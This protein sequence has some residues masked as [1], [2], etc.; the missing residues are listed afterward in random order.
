MSQPLAEMR[1]VERGFRVGGGLFGSPRDLRAVNGVSLSI[2]SGEALGIVGES[3][4]GKSTLARM[5]LGL[6]APS[7]GEVFLDGRPIASLGARALARCVQ[8]VFQDPYSSLN[9]RRSVGAI[10]AAPLVVH[11]IGNAAERRAEVERLIHLV[12]LAPRLYA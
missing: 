8:P 10:I 12:G 1:N 5:L 6:L 3:G 4:C 11:R 7:A 9:P 2:R